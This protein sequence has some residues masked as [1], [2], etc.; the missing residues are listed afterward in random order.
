MYQLL[1]KYKNTQEFN[2]KNT[3]WGK[4]PCHNCQVLYCTAW[5]PKDFFFKKK[6]EGGL[7][8]PSRAA[9][10]KTSKP[11]S[12][13]LAYK[14]MAPGKE[15]VRRGIISCKA[16]LNPMAISFSAAT[17]DPFLDLELAIEI[18]AGMHPIGPTELTAIFLAP[19][20]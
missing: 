17:Q 2:W 3:D 9:F 20:L 14:I 10:C 8:V 18:R 6:T 12:N 1:L 19:K 15:L 4:C 16:A 5:E 7:S 13:V 11:E